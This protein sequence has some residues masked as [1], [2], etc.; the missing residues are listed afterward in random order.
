MHS[1]A[2]LIWITEPNIQE[3]E[4]QKGLFIKTLNF[5]RA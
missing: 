1:G 2:A 3:Q 5:F 4:K